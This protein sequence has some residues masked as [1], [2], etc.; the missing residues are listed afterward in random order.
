[1]IQI[2]DD[3]QHQIGS[4]L[5]LLLFKVRPQLVRVYPASVDSQEMMS[6]MKRPS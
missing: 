6:L 4:N 2:L 5:C 3:F 1:M